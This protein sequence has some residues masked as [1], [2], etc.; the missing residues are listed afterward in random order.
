[1]VTPTPALAGEGPGDHQDVQSEGPRQTV[2]PPAL[3]WASVHEP[4]S[5]D[6]RSFRT[7]AALSRYRPTSVAN[8]AWQFQATTDTSPRQGPP[9]RG[10]WRAAAELEGEIAEV[11]AARSLVADS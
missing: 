11:G 7:Y 1:M 3:P 9:A 6:A 4:I 2:L 5:R 10:S 8:I